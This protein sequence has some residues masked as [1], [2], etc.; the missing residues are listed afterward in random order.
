MNPDAAAVINESHLAKAVHEETDPRP[1]RA[2]H[3]V[4]GKKGEVWL[5]YELR[6]GATPA[7]ISRI[8][9][10]S[11]GRWVALGTATTIRE[12]QR[13]CLEPAMC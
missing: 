9:W 3:V 7:V 11:A 8:Q 13:R 1:R 2:D 6:R 10:D 12:S 5:R 4:S